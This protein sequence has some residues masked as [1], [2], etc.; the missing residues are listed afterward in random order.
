M[1]EVPD[2]PDTDDDVSVR[3]NE[4]MKQQKLMAVTQAESETEQQK[5]RQRAELADHRTRLLKAVK[6]EAPDLAAPLFE[7]LSAL[8][9]E[10][11]E[12]A[13]REVVDLLKVAA[14]QKKSSETQ[15][16]TFNAIGGEE[17]VVQDAAAW[18]ESLYDYRRWA[19]VQ[20]ESLIPT[21]E[22]LT[23]NI[24]KRCRGVLEEYSLTRTK[25]A[26]LRE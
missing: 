9:Y 10:N 17:A 15:N 1:P 4:V 16:M 18:A 21:L 19:N 11:H 7:K 20:R 22:L 5:K 23:E 26:L 14:K 25:P 24:S 6:V 12:F 3:R 13:P 8:A 2:V